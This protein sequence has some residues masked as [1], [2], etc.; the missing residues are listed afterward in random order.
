MHP[1]QMGHPGMQPHPAMFYPQQHQQNFRP[2]HPYPPNYGGFVQPGANNAEQDKE[3]TAKFATEQL[4]DGSARTESEKGPDKEQAP[5]TLA[6]INGDMLE[7][8]GKGSPA[9]AAG[10]KIVAGED[11]DSI[12]EDNF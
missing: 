3:G 9:G 1:M 4:V 11:S 12:F 6:E 8:E 2:P 5:L 10:F 7:E